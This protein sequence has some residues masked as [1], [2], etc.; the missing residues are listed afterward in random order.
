MGQKLY[1]TEENGAEK[2]KKWRKGKIGREEYIEIREGLREF[3][4]K[5]QKHKREEEEK[6][7]KSLRNEAELWKYINRKRKK[8]ER[9]ENSISK[10]RWKEYFVKL[11]D[12]VRGRR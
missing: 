1:E 5:K 7:L 3:L 11:L 6:E 12:G 10:E 8:Y 9:K 2:Y 4:R